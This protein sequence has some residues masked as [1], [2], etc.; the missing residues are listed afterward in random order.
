MQQPE[1]GAAKQSP[2]S[3]APKTS[4]PLICLVPDSVIKVNQAQSN[5]AA[6]GNSLRAGARAAWPGCSLHLLEVGNAGGFGRDAAPKALTLP[7]PPGQAAGAQKGGKGLV[8]AAAG[9]WSRGG[10]EGAGRGEELSSNQTWT[11][12]AS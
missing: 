3:E 9:M 5:T 2:T 4:Q 12:D 6:P 11:D 7:V 8:G 1:Q 10:S